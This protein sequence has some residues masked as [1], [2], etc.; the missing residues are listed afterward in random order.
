MSSTAKPIPVWLDC[1]VGHDDAMAIILAAYH[2]Q[3][4]LVG[5]SSVSGN[6]SVENTTANAVRMLQVAGIKGVKVYRGAAKPLVKPVEYAADIHGESGLEGTDLLPNPDYDSHFVEGVHAVNAMREAIM[7]SDEP[8]SVVAVG[9]LTNIALLLSLYPEV[10]AKISTLSIM[11]GSIGIGNT[12]AAAEFNIL[13]DPEAAQIVF[14]SG[15]QNIVLVPLDVTHT[16]LSTRAVIE[17]IRESITSPNF[18]KLVCD[19]LQHFS[20][21]YATVFGIDE[22]A[23]LHDPLAIAYLVKQDAFT[24]KLVR[25]DVDCNTGYSNG[26]TLCD[27]FRKSQRTPNCWVTT[28][29]DVDWFWNEMISALVAAATKRT[30]SLLEQIADISDPKPKDFDIENADL[31]DTA[32]TGGGGSG[33]E[34]ESSDDEDMKR[35]HYIEVGKSSLR[36]Q[37]GMGELGPKYTG[38]RVSRKD[39]YES[40]DEQEEEEE[41]SGDGSGSDEDIASEEISDKDSGSD[42]EL[43]AGRVSGESEL[44]SDSD[45]EGNRLMDFAA[46]SDAE[47]NAAESRS[48]I[49]E[50]IRKLEEGEKALL[51]SITQ[52]ARSDVEKGQHVL[53][54]TR[55]WEGALDARIRVQKLVAAADELP[56]FDL[57]EELVESRFTGSGSDDEK[58][59][60][61]DSEINKLERAR[62]SVGLLLSSLVDLRRSLAEQNP[63]A[64][65]SQEAVHANRKKRKASR[66]ADEDHDIVVTWNELEDLREGFLPYRNESLEKWSNK[67]QISASVTANKKFKAINQGILHQISQTLAG[68]ERLIERTQLKR[69]EYKV[70]GKEGI[71]SEGDEAAQGMPA[72]SSVA[73]DAHLKDRDAEIFDDTD[74]YQQLL[75]ELIESRMVDT[76]DPTA[77]LGVRWAAVKQQSRSKK[78]SVDTKASKGRKI[79]YHVMEKLQNFMPPIPAGDWHEDMINELFSSLLGQRV[80]MSMLDE[81][82]GESRPSTITQALMQ[83]NETDVSGQGLRLFG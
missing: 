51:K 20:Y 72:S 8:I 56:R 77:S 54:Q 6:A 38:S 60:D 59:E 41:D 61:A 15:I 70:I 53:N 43:D 40:E 67:V 76:N 12:T 68:E 25:V 30:K 74:F 75:R 63:A 57:F 34:D 16:V 35:E 37:Q 66:S 11:G 79:R 65:Q 18:G 49:R 17:R 45:D 28:S 82:L 27:M 29:V 33:S 24:K 46:D 13:C 7:G 2:P 48:R 78:R 23:P 14:N 81:D 44:E 32:Y 47:E 42:D 50:E 1:D 5:I 10:T 83:A 69:A 58:E 52:T 19:L 64:K 31:N 4:R 3:I 55:L 36:R 26:R 80:P 22:G 71:E 62:E 21:T 39:L 73:V 9:P